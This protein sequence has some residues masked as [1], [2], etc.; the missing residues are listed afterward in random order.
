MY[1]HR[2]KSHRETPSHNKPGAV[3][4]RADELE[5]RKRRITEMRARHHDE[6]RGALG[7]RH[8]S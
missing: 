2:P 1:E 4:S 7:V 3:P 6:T 5:Q 8:R